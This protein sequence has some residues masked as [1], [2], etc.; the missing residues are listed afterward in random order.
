MRR[1][2]GSL[3]VAGLCVAAALAAAAEV[4]LATQSTPSM[5][6]KPSRVVSLSR[7]VCFGMCPEYDVTLYADG[8]LEYEGKDFVKVQGRKTKRVDAATMAKVTKAIAASGIQRLD[9]HCCDCQ[10][11]T[12]HPTATIGFESEGQWK[13]IVD[14]HGCTKSPRAVRDLEETLDKLLG[15]QEFVGTLEERTHRPR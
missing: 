3:V 2:G 8:T 15:T 12:D 1:P 4:L 6:T 7:T 9:A 13:T 11:W 14:Y 10:E 5:P